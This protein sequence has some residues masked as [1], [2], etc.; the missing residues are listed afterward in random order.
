MSPGGPAARM[1]RRLALAA[2]AAL[3]VLP[4]TAHAAAPASPTPAHVSLATKLGPYAVTITASRDAARGP[5]SL[6]VYL[7]RGDAARDEQT[8]A[9]AFTLPAGAVAVDKRLESARVRA[10][11]GTFGSLDLRLTGRG[12]TTVATPLQPCSGPG[13]QDRA[14]RVT[15]SLTLNLGALGTLRSP[16]KARLD[17]LVRRG[18][19]RCP[20]QRCRV[21]PGT[22]V[23]GVSV[24]RTY[25]A[26]QRDA[27]GK[28]YVFATV[29]EQPSRRA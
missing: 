2:I 28:T 15:G 3:C 12:A 6:V 19:V 22:A 17:R 27:A 8:H 25:V 4:P 21:G 24:E 7:R 5:G 26:L 23:A 1:A 29:S 9:F 11:L 18:A 16:G 10:Q 13:S 20:A 14:A